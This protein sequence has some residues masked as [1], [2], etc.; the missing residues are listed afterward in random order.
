MTI[1]RFFLIFA[2]ALALQG[3]VFALYYDDL[4]YL[5]QPV[6]VIAA[7]AS[8]TF[9]RHAASALKREELTGAHLDTIAAAAERLKLNDIEVTALERHATM[10]PADLD[11]RLRLADA[12]RRAGRYQRAELLYLEILEFAPQE[13]R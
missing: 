3:T 4:I 11:I 13:T 9:A 1:R 5:R 8:G 2:G 7:D 12:L 6:A 10:R